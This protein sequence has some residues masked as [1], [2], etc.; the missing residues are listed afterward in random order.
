MALQNYINEDYCNSCKTKH[1]VNRN[2]VGGFK[3]PPLFFY[4]CI[5]FNCV[6]T[7]IFF[8]YH[9]MAEQKGK[10]TIQNRK[11]IPKNQNMCKK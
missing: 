1:H 4:M 7:V 5:A 2:M 8:F 3:H 10:R 9:D 11:R 6:Q